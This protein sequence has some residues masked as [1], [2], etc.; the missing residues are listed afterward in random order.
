MTDRQTKTDLSLTSIKTQNQLKL[1]FK[2]NNNC[3]IVLTAIRPT[4]LGHEFN[5][6]LEEITSEINI[7]S[8]LQIRPLQRSTGK[9]VFRDWRTDY[10]TIY[11]RHLTKSKYIQ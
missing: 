7:Y 11:R 2:A 6:P 1:L 10:V 3:S 4:N 9:P 5:E 8:P